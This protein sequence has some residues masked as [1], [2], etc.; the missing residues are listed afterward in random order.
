MECLRGTEE[1]R[2]TK[3]FTLNIFFV[4]SN[5]DILNYMLRLISALLLALVI[6]AFIIQN[7]SF[8]IVHFLAWQFEGSLA[9]LLFLTFIFGVIISLLVA[10]PLIFRRK[11]KTLSTKEKT[12]IS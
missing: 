7:T 10:I 8:V 2:L 9:L 4:F 6:V 1:K 11:T 5:C 3:E 12:K